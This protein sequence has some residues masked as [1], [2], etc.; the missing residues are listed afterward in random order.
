VRWKV[1]RWAAR[2][3]RK[4]DERA[5]R[6]QERQRERAR[7][8]QMTAADRWMARAQ[9]K[10]DERAA[11][12]QEL[13]PLRQLVTAAPIRGPGD[14]AAVISIDQS[15][16][17]WLSPDP[18]PPQMI[19][20]SSRLRWSADGQAGCWQSCRVP[21]SGIEVPHDPGPGRVAVP[22]GLGF[23]ALLRSRCRTGRP[24]R[25]HLES[26]GCEE[27]RAG[28]GVRSLSP[29]AAH[30]LPSTAAMKPS[31]SMRLMVSELTFILRNSVLGCR[32]V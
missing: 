15:G 17:W 13:E 24:P 7:S 28:P 16:T 2:A 31:G 26:S 25:T 22:K 32:G 21:L 12:W 11:R 5:A 27:D 6:W 3:Q 10:S 4:S 1:D 14:S 23:R 29:R 9:R 19:T 20:S 8:G 30:Y 18:G